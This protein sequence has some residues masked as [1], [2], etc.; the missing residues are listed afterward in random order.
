[1]KARPFLAAFLL[2]AC[3][4]GAYQAGGAADKEGR[5]TEDRL[6]GML[7]AFAGRSGERVAESVA[8]A[9]ALERSDDVRLR[10]RRMNLYFTTALFSA[11][12]EGDPQTGLLNAAVTVSLER[13]IVASPRGEALYG[14]AGARLFRG[15]FDAL[16]PEVRDM[17]RR[18]FTPD[19]IAEV[20]RLMEDWKRAH[21]GA[22]SARFVR[23]T[24][25][26]RDRPDPVQRGGLLA[27]VKE[28]NRQVE[29]VRRLGAKA[30]FL[31]QNLPTFVRWQGLDFVQETLA[32]PQVAR[33]LKQ[34]DPGRAVAQTDQVVRGWID[35]AARRAVQVGAALF[36]MML[37]YRLILLLLGGAGRS[38][39]RARSGLDRRRHSPPQ[40][41]WPGI[42]RRRTG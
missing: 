33:I 36:G 34:Y 20:D 37:L 16:E 29:E 19:Q 1:M 5:I 24:D 41:A 6:Q 2:L 23:F 38:A 3:A 9:L 4:G 14:K 42:E 40:P 28:A 10:C 13:W 25:F 15:T 26:I 22:L 31:A 21:P 12:L 17:E 18:V 11:A 35:R 7:A 32:S 8:R 39:R 27:P 30:L